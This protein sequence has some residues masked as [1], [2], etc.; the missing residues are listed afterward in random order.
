MIIKII[1]SHYY[2]YKIQIKLI[3][4]LN[5]NLIYYKIIK[6]LVKNIFFIKKNNFYINKKLQIYNNIMKNLIQFSFKKI[7]MNNK[8]NKS[9]KNKDF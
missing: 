9:F 1:K 7:K 3:K 2:N 5:C 6:V 8:D 4:I